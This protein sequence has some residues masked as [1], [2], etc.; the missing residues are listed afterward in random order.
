[1]GHQTQVKNI[2][3]QQKGAQCRVALWRDNADANIQLGD[4][5]EMTNVVTKEY[6]DEVYVQTTR[7]TNLK[8]CT[9]PFNLKPDHSY[10]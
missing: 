2:T 9:S 6:L 5:M 3:I 10:S 1:M 7:L 4:H 8:V